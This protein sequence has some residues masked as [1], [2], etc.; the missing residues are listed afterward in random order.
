[1]DMKIKTD[2]LHIAN[3]QI[4]IEILAFQNVIIEML[5]M[6]DNKYT[7][8]EINSIQQTHINRIRN[9]VYTE[10]GKTPDLGQAE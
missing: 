2:D 9:H 10:F 3:C 7:P 1:M 8:D 5:L 4:L 6:K